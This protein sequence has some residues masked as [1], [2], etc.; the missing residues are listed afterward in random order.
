M[1][2]E[3]TVHKWEYI[4]YISDAKPRQEILHKLISSE[5]HS[6]YMHWMK[7]KATRFVQKETQ[8][9]SYLQ[10]NQTCLLQSVPLHCWYTAPN[11]SISGMHPGMRF[12]R[13]H[14]GP[15]VNFLLSPLI[16]W[17]WQ[18]FQVDFNFGNEKSPQRPNLDSRMVG[19]MTVVLCFTKSHG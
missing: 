7:Y 6:I 18:P 15:V 16:V 19:G 5:W 3:K 8:L 17:N 11:I 4:K 12:A 2:M 1:C 14:T 9:F 13:W 10:F